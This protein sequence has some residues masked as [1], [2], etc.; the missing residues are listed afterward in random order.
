MLLCFALV[1]GM[2]SCDK[3]LDFHSM[4]PQEESISSTVGS[5]VY[6]VKPGDSVLIVLAEENGLNELVNA[7]VYVD[8]AINVGLISMLSDTTV[9][10]TILAPTDMAFYEFYDALGVGGIMDL[11]PE[12]VLSILEFH[13][14]QGRLISTDVIP[15]FG[16]RLHQT[17]LG[18]AIQVSSD[19]SIKA[20]SNGAQ[21]IDVDLA[22]SNGIIHVL[23][24]VLI[25]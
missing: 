1:L 18:E 12:Q 8:T 10:H 7:I 6:T 5:S 23:D 16:S 3:D 2:A 15:R 4:T 20:N 14:L 21:I 22:A 17:L 19:A 11:T 9:D 25:P 24:N 13:I